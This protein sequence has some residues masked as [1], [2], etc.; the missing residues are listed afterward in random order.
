MCGDYK[1]AIL[2]IYYYLNEFALY[3]AGAKFCRSLSLCHDFHTIEILPE[4]IACIRIESQITMGWE[5]FIQKMLA[6]QTLA[7]AAECCTDGFTSDGAVSSLAS[8]ALHELGEY[9]LILYCKLNLL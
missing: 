8:L 6:N 5:V 4:I 9:R 3:L 7:A 2:L 1:N